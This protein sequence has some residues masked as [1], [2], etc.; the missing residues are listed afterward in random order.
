MHNEL[1][2][3]RRLGEKF[4]EASLWPANVL[5]VVQVHTGH[6]YNAQC[7]L[8][9][10]WLSADKKSPIQFYYSGTTWIA[11]LT[12]LNLWGCRID[13]YFWEDSQSRLPTWKI[14]K[15]TFSESLFELLPHEKIAVW[16][17]WLTCH[18]GWSKPG[19][20]SIHHESSYMISMKTPESGRN[21]ACNPLQCNALLCPG[22]LP[23]VTIHV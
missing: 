8:S 21:S 2:C 7:F 3:L 1:S 6:C 9:A 16:H 23:L 19:A 14:S 18:G 13:I 10:K 5:G 22:F 20:S 12:G 4:E 15:E 11:S 17:W